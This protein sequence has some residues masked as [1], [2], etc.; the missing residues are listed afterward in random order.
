VVLPPNCEA[1]VN[2]AAV[3][4]LPATRPTRYDQ[5]KFSV[6]GAAVCPR[7]LVLALCW[8][9]HQRVCDS[10]TLVVQGFPPINRCQDRFSGRSTRLRGALAG[11]LHA[12]LL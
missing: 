2:R 6:H 3:R 7:P 5:A 12:G 1:A 10:K 4:N 9:L 11:A 8:V